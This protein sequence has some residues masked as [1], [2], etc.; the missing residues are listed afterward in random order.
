MV[1]PKKEPTSF[2][3]R[4]EV[5]LLI[6]QAIS[7][8]HQGKIYILR[9][10]EAPH[11][12]A[13][14]IPMDLDKKFFEYNLLASEDETLINIKMLAEHLQFW[15]VRPWTKKYAPMTV[16][17]SYLSKEYKKIAFNE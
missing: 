4:K 13:I 6:A 10:R 8:L 12:E 16:N 15:E 5:F 3:K 7:R 14:L 17:W 11:D 2:Q 1:K 9:R